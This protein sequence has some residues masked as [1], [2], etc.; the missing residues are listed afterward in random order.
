M[1]SGMR[2]KAGPLSRVFGVALLSAG[3]GIGRRPRSPPKSF[4]A[5]S[6]SRSNGRSADERSPAVRESETYDPKGVPLGGFKLFG[7]LEADEV[8]NDNIIR[9]VERDGQAGRASFS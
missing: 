5:L 9:H 7:T 3:Y 8:F 1:K 4:L 6:A 2:M